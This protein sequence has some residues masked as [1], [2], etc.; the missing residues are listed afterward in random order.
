MQSSKKFYKY[1]F[2]L[3]QEEKELI[4]KIKKLHRLNNKLGNTNQQYLD[5][6]HEMNEYYQD[7]LDKNPEVV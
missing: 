7:I 4:F 6:I 2:F 1:N 5:F 3:L